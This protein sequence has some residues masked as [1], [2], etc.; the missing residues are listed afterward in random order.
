VIAASEEELRTYGTY[1]TPGYFGDRL[2]SPKFST[3]PNR[4]GVQGLCHIR[5]AFYTR[6]ALLNAAFLAHLCLLQK[7]ACV[8]LLPSAPDVTSLGRSTIGRATW[9][10]LLSFD[11]QHCGAISEAGRSRPYVLKGASHEL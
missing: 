8:H 9:V 5:D 6:I 3:A 10:N 11:P 7:E 1:E 4:D 2:R